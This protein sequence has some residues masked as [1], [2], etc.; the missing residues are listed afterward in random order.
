M[1]TVSFGGPLEF[2]VA[3]FGDSV[4]REAQNDRVPADAV[5]TASIAPASTTFSIASR[6]RAASSAS[7]FRR[8]ADPVACGR[9]LNAELRR[10]R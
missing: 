1:A 7:R 8:L 2:G 5:V 6:P 10:R 4:T 9:L 3:G